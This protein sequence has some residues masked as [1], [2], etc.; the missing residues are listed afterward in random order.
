M[1]N[2]LNHAVFPSF[3]NQAQSDGRVDKCQPPICQYGYDFWVIK[4][5]DDKQLMGIIK[6]HSPQN[7]LLFSPCIEI[8]WRLDKVN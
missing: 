7:D 8:S 6:R 5:K 1:S 4:P 2:N 3:L